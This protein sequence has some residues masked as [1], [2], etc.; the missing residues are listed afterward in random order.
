MAHDLFKQYGTPSKNNFSQI[1]E[2]VKQ[3]Q[4]ELRGDP[5]EIVQRLLYSGQMTQEQFNQFAEMATQILPNI[6]G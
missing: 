3:M 6:I 4:K 1:A 2:S 5:R